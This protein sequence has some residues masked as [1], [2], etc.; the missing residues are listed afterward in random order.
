MF[1]KSSQIFDCES[2][3]ERLVDNFGSPKNIIAKWVENQGRAPITQRVPIRLQTAWQMVGL[4]QDFTA[5]IRLSD[6]HS[7][8]KQLDANETASIYY[9][10]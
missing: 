9:D 1:R 2:H 3:G 4:R 10:T 6:G 7:L 8:M 5:N